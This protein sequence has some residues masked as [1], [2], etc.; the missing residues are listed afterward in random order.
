MAKKK[1]RAS[2]RSNGIHDKDTTIDKA[3]RRSKSVA[4]KMLNKVKAWRA[5]KNPW[6]LNSQTGK[7]S[8]ANDYFGDYKAT[9]M[10]MKTS[11]G[12]VD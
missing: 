10:S 3:V 9:R 11:E 6:V 5:G 12:E 7:L 2:R 1:L 8:R 4:T